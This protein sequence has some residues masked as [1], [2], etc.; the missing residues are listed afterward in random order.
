MNRIHMLILGMMVATY[1]PRLIP[2]LLMGNKKIPAKIEEFL[3]YIPYAA[4][5]ALIIPGFATA[6]PGHFTASL[7]G[8][9]VALVIGFYKHGVVLPVIGA[10]LAS[11]VLISI[12]L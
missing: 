11:M 8:I 1:L 12:G 5:G 7:I 6:I 3:S 2:F 10:I 9:L 4:L